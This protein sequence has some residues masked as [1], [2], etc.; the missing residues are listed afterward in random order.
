M[1]FTD[2]QKIS[3]RR[4]CGYGAFGG[5]Q[6]LP[7]N[8]LRFAERY[9]ALEYRM[10]S[11]SANEELVVTG[12]I[13]P[14]LDTLYAD[15][16]GSA[17]V[18][19]NLDTAEAAAWKANPKERTERMRLYVQCRR[20]LCEFMGVPYGPALDSNNSGLSFIV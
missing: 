19:S 8:G 5:A 14:N 17:G 20:D 4:Y 11:L 9:G 15:L 10:L 7:A 18:R 12:T 2:A 16:F 1:A 6:P 3:I 13:L